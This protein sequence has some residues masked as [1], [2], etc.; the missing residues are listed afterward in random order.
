MN[1]PVWRRHAIRNIYD[2]TI[3]EFV[4]RYQRGCPTIVLL[5]GGM[6][7]QLKRSTDAYQKNQVPSLPDLTYEVVWIDEKAIAFG[8]LPLLRIENRGRDFDSHSIVANGPICMSL[9]DYCPYDQTEEFFHR[10]GINYIVF[11]YDWR[12]SLGESAK[13]L[14]YFLT[15]LKK[16]VVQEHKEDPLPNVTLL[17]HSMGGLVAKIFLHEVDNIGEWI[18]QLITVATPFYGTSTHQQRY[19]IGLDILEGFNIQRKEMASITASLPGTYNLMFLPKPIFKEY[20]SKIGLKRYPIR[21]PN[22]DAG[23]DPF[24]ENSLLLYPEWVSSKHL[25][26]AGSLYNIISE[27]FPDDVAQRV[28]N[29]RSV[30]NEET[31]VELAWHRLPEDFDPD[32]EE[33]PDD[34]SPVRTP[35]ESPVKVFTKGPGDGTVPAWSAYHVSVP[36]E[37]RRELTNSKDHAFLMEDLQVLEQVD[38]WVNDQPTIASV[39]EVR[40]LLRDIATGQVSDDDSRLTDQRIGRRIYQGLAG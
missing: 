27:P 40:K 39:S 33:S 11:G 19:F 28:Y 14:K 25:A 31:P 24:A 23:A 1:Y 38:T 8:K 13:F 29:I 36:N 9:G 20:K 30:G 4:D 6:G 34:E 22:G 15:Q 17:A 21:N 2:S 37:N 35:D 18:K 16:L 26:A 32:E 10:K 5:P 7:T 3:S 12:R